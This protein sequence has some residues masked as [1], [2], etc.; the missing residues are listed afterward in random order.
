MAAAYRAVVGAVWA[1]VMC[2]C[3]PFTAQLSFPFMYEEEENMRIPDDGEF[4]CVMC[5]D[6]PVD[7]EQEL[8]G[9]C[10]ME[11]AEQMRDD[12]FDAF[13]RRYM[14]EALEQEQREGKL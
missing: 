9:E 5:Q 8:C 3:V 10:Q 2:G 1:A 11:Q 12:G 14:R 13:V 6:V 4:L 7:D